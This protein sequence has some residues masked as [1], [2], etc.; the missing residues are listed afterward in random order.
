MQHK[1]ILQG[2]SAAHLW[3]VF[4]CLYAPNKFWP[5][6]LIKTTIVFLFKVT[7]RG[8]YID[9]LMQ[10]II[11]PVLCFVLR[12][13]VFW[14][15]CANSG[16]ILSLSLQSRDAADKTC[17]RK[18]Y[19]CLKNIH[20]IVCLLVHVHISIDFQIIGDFQLLRTPALLY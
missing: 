14:Q 20:N 13:Y 5:K 8:Y 10:F 2:S 15:T 4:E 3:Y 6:T 19:F 16:P 17:Y 18:L 9:L 7:L 12:L 11:H 1:A